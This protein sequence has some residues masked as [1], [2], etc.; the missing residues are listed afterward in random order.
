M[1]ARRTQEPRWC[2]VDHATQPRLRLG[3][4][5]KTNTYVDDANVG[6]WTDQRGNRR[7]TIVGAI[8]LE[9]KVGCRLMVDGNK[10][11]SG[12]KK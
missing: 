1:K 4:Y 10:R 8:V 5:L 6:G 9:G 11:P 7:R 12:W 2:K 3:E